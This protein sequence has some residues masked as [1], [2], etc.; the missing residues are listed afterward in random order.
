MYICF[1]LFE[2]T[3]IENAKSKRKVETLFGCTSDERIEESDSIR[4]NEKIET[5]EVDES[6]KELFT[7]E[8]R[9]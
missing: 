3:V 7:C 6:G 2:K 5:N 9:T 1:S 4:R 8:N